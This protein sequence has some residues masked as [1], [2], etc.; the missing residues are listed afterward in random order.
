MVIFEVK[1][2]NKT[3]LDNLLEV[4]EGSVKA[5]HTFLSNE[6]IENIKKYVPQALKN[7][8]HLIIAENE[9]NIP[10]A[11]MGI[12]DMRLEMLFVKSN[13]RGKGIGKKIL[14]YGIEK[15]NV[16]ELTVNEQNS[17][18]KGFYE[19]LGFKV[20]KRSDTDEQG[21]PYP[22]LYMKI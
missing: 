8:T 21:N 9:N 1:I 13:E 2:R 6:E 19:Y 10:I 18:V 20:Y 5:T 15:Y 17:K 14:N 12:E 7:V 3:L 16:N 4:W 22:I 11:F